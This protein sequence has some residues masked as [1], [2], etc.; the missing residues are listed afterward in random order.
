MATPT[1]DGK[2]LVRDANADGILSAVPGAAQVDEITDERSRIRFD[3]DFTSQ[4]VTAAQYD[5]RRAAAD[6]EYARLVNVLV[7]AARARLSP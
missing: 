5:A 2:F 7:A 6:I 1:P 3:G 4:G